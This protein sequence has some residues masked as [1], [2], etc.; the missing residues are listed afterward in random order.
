MI[1]SSSAITTRT[2]LVTGSTRG[3]VG[4]VSG[5]RARRPCGRAARPARAASS[6]IERARARRGGGARA[7]AWRRASRAPRRRPRGVSDDERPQAGVFGLLLEERALLLGD[8]ELGAQALEPFADVDEPPLEEGLGHGTRQ[9]TARE[10]W[11]GSV[12]RARLA[13]ASRT[14]SSRRSTTSCGPRC[15]GSSTPRSG[16]HVDEWEAAGLLPRRRVPALRRARVPRAA[17]PGAV[18]RQRRRPR[19]G[20]RVR[21]GAGALRV[22]L[23]SRWRS[24]CRPT[25]HARARASSGPTTSASAGCARRS[26]ARRSAPS[27]SPSPTPAPTSPRSRTRAVRDGDIWRINGRKMFITNG[28][29]ARLP[30]AGRADRPRLGASR[31]L[32]VHRRHVV[33]RACRCRASS[34]SSACARQRHRRDRARRRRRARTTNL[35]G[36]TNPGE[37]SRS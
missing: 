11:C 36:G 8:G 19:R 35:I 27:R 21:R 22:R 15:A 7:S 6:A 34:R 4:Y 14:R 10:P 16:R 25:W 9:S 33:A 2:A 20:P 18:G 32:A 31:H 37:G 30:H 12:Q 28:T 24:R 26:P 23:R 3:I 13:D 1:A 5:R 29:R 17:L